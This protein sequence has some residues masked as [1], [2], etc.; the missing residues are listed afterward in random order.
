MI[1]AALLLLSLSTAS[2]AQRPAR[3]T[4]ASLGEG[5]QSLFALLRTPFERP[6]GD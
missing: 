4:P 2:L 5:E 3:F 1:A 6:S